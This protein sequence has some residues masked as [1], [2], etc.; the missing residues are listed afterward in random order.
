LPMKPELTF[1]LFCLTFY[2]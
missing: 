2:L 1:W